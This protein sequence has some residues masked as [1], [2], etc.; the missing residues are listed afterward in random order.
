MPWPMGVGVVVRACSVQ[1]RGRIKAMHRD[2]ILYERHLR[3]Q[4][5]WTKAKRQEAG[6]QFGLLFLAILLVPFVRAGWQA[7]LLLLGF[8]GLLVL[9]TVVVQHAARK[10]LSKP[11]AVSPGD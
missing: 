10:S 2:G 7:M 6:S 8:F 11:P 4:R 1:S 3:K 9:A 5:R